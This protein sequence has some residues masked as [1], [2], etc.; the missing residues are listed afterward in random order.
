MEI[1]RIIGALGVYPG[2]P[3]PEWDTVCVE[4]PGE[5]FAYVNT[6]PGKERVECMT[7][8]TWATYTKHGLVVGDFA[9]GDESKKR[10]KEIVANLKGKPN[11]YD[12]AKEARKHRR[13]VYEP[14]EK[15]MLREAVREYKRWQRSQKK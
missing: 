12:V 14:I 8:G 1:K 4:L 10:A 5:V 6:T 15:E 9:A 7:Y 11:G 2:T 3:Y 13:D